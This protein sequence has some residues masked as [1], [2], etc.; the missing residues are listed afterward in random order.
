MP[1]FT[2]S[3]IIIII[4]S[5]SLIT[6]FWTYGLPHQQQQLAQPKLPAINHYDDK[7][8]H[9]KSIV[10]PSVG[11]VTHAIAPKPTARPEQSADSR[12]DD[13]SKDNTKE[14]G[15]P[16]EDPK[17]GKILLA[18]S[19]STLLTKATPAPNDAN[20]TKPTPSS[21]A[22]VPIPTHAV[23]KFCKD[24]AGAQHVMVILK[25]SKAEIDTLSSHFRALLSCVPHFA[26]FSD[27]AGGFN[28]YPVY[29]ALDSI[30]DRI[31]SKHAE[32][33]EYQ[34]TDAEHKSDPKKMKDLDKW[35]MLPMV[36]KAYHLKP[37]A[38]FFFFI[39]AETSLSWTN[40]LQWVNR[41]D[42]RI[43]YYSGA[44]IFNSGTQMV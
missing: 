24:V 10:P 16:K 44:P 1:L 32:F 33:D 27:H 8:V 11:K 43:P 7:N 4:V 40:L 5:F 3:R 38:R 41:L 26:I 35:K 22:V 12:W 20:A 9:S 23:E 6:F 25:T 34:V 13:K 15:E 2:P 18:S 30:S 29:D 37:D 17:S 36:Y 21:A 31:K 19:S 14:K 28:G 42:Y 39:E